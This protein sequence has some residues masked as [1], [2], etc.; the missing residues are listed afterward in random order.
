[1]N[2]IAKI[3]NFD[4]K[5]ELSQ[6]SVKI[7]VNG[8]VHL[9]LKRSYILGYQSWIEGAKEPWVYNIEFSLRRHQTVLLQY[10]MREKWGL[11]LR[12]LDALE[13]W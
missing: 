5:T 4:V 2:K 11:V 13:I 9:N 8:I 7:Y 10:D 12:E 1:M 6:R 3:R